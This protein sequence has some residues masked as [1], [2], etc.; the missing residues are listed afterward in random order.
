MSK[1]FIYIHN[2]KNVLMSN[3]HAVYKHDF[4]REKGDK[5]DELFDYWHVL[6]KYI[7]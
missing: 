5:P 3:L 7:Y 4:Y 2:I 6:L 1:H